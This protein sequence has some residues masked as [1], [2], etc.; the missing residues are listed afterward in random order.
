M[1]YGVKKCLYCC[2]DFVDT[3]KSG[4]KLYCSPNHKS[5]FMK[6]KHAQKVKESKANYYTNNKS[7]ISSDNLK[8]LKSK[9]AAVSAGT[10]TE[11]DINI[12][13]R[14]RVRTRLLK[15][16]RKSNTIKDTSIVT[17][18]GCNLFELKS[19]LESKFVEGMSWGNRKGW[20]IDHI[21]PLSAF[22]LSD[23]EQLRKACHYTNLQPLWA[24]DNIIKSNKLG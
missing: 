11:K 18:V 20:H 17:L 13:L 15:A 7:K 19:H 14:I 24:K 10:A 8:W 21:I 9:Y 12:I 16:L 1:A 23:P 3:T 22:D 2:S 6:K 4:N 5:S